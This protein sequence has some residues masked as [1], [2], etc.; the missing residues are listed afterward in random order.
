MN[1]Y[2]LDIGFC[3]VDWGS[4]ASE[5]RQS[6]AFGP[7]CGPK[8]TGNGIPR[9]AGC[10]GTLD[11]LHTDIDTAPAGLLYAVYMFQFQCCKLTDR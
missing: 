1:E 10:S 11:Q 5:W 4:V 6:A 2:R 7:K 3:V 9:D 8:S